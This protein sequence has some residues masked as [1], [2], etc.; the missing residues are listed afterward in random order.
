MS[1]MYII[2][3]LLI[4][5]TI[6][7]VCG[8]I[9]IKAQNSGWYPLFLQS[10][11]DTINTDYYQKILDIGTGP[12]KLP[13][14]LIQKDSSLHII[15]IDI[16]ASYIDAAR[17]RVKHPNVSFQ[18]ENAGEKLEFSDNEFDV[19]TFC[20]V[21]FLLDNNTKTFL[22]NEAARVLKPSGKIIVLSPS[23]EK[24]IFSSIREINAFPKSRYNWTYIIWK[25]A[26]KNRG[27]KWQKSNWLK[28][29]S[30]TKK[31]KY[32]RTSTFNNNASIEI[33]TKTIQ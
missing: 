21:L 7:T 13:E 15:G 4:M 18:H 9:F 2:I 33:L 25:T 22:V 28:E 17:R 26:T 29:F 10:V 24:S 20:S 5:A 32:L 16:N 1:L 19:V 11:I 14:L 3:L 27:N 12:G 30:N 23:G 6:A 31:M 8:S